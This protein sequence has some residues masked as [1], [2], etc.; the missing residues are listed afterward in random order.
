MK[1]VDQLVIRS[2][3]KE[4][5]EM[6]I[7]QV[8]R[9]FNF[10]DEMFRPHMSYHVNNYPQYTRLGF[11]QDILTSS[12][13]IIP[14]T[15]YFRGAEIKFGGLACVGTLATYRHRGFIEK[16]LVDSMR[17]MREDGFLFSGLYTG[18]HEVYR[19]HGYENCSQ[20]DI[21]L[22]LNN[23]PGKASSHTQFNIIPFHTKYLPQVMDIYEKY[24][25]PMTGP[26][27]R[28]K[29]YW[30]AQNK[31]NES[32]DY[33]FYLITDKRNKIL[34]YFRGG[35][36]KNRESG[37][38]REAC[39][40]PNQK[41]IW[42]FIAQ[43][44]I[45]IFNENRMTGSVRLP[46]C[47]TTHPLK[48]SYEQMGLPIKIKKNNGL[49]LRVIHLPKLFQKITESV[50]KLNW[51]GNIQ[52]I[53]PV[54][55]V[56]LHVKGNKLSFDQKPAEKIIY[57]TNAALMEWVTGFRLF[58]ELSTFHEDISINGLNPEDIE[59]LDNLLPKVLWNYWSTDA[60]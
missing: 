40:C 28:N 32:R 16:I 13:Q 57:L 53:A 3:R 45:S 48:D 4:E 1:S 24:S 41:E 9:T 52:I 20:K 27:V 23:T 31:W 46:C 8:V 30:D 10:P 5:F 7:E 47:F 12:L 11:Y 42:D 14:K 43:S 58:S 60:Y 55:K 2:A 25:H 38:I 50:A 26:V 59:F 56:T 19:P 17:L 39:A 36:A 51:Q 44:S 34:G 29:S 18:V 54:D 35:M 49:M 37:W 21:L 22:T 33:L 6:I 15:V